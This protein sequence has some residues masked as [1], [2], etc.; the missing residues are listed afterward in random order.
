MVWLKQNIEIT[1]APGLKGNGR[2]EDGGMTAEKKR[3]NELL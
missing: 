2:R 3:E 1:T